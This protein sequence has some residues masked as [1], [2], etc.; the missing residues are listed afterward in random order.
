MLMR[1]TLILETA[2]R[3]L[4]LSLLLLPFTAAPAQSSR[5]DERENDPR[6][7]TRIAVLAVSDLPAD[8][9]AVVYLCPRAQPSVVIVTRADGASS[10]DLA[11]GYETA[12]KLV[13]SQK[14]RGADLSQGTQLLRVVL[15]PANVSTLSAGQ[16]SAF[17][18]YRANLRNAPRMKLPGIGEGRLLYIAKRG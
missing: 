6:T 11:A 16:Q 14:M 7:T 17:D 5:D 8:Q 1:P 13:R 10:A 9:R 15:G 2:R 18:G 3:M 4:A 12:L